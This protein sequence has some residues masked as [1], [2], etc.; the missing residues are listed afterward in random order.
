MLQP[1]LEAP[2]APRCGRAFA[3]A[4]R[5]RGA[6]GGA[7]YAPLTLTGD[8]RG[9]WCLVLRRKRRTARPG[10]APG[11]AREDEGD[12]GKRCRYWDW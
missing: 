11:A 2:G 8:R 12:S 4:G 1:L 3:A 10:A 9:P 7:A 5:A 6:R